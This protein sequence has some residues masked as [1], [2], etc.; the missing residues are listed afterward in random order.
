MHPGPIH[1]IQIALICRGWCQGARGWCHVR[2][3][4]MGT[5]DI[6]SADKH[7]RERKVRLADNQKS[8]FAPSCFFFSPF[9]PGLALSHS[10]LLFVLSYPIIVHSENLTNH[11]LYSHL[12]QRLDRHRN[13]E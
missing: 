2:H 8:I 5:P 7:V 12:T 9:S 10:F 11:S 6:P 1:E 4:H 13:I 3:P